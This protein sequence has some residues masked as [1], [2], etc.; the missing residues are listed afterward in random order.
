LVQCR[1]KGAANYGNKSEGVAEGPESKKF[2][3]TYELQNG[4]VKE[5]IMIGKDANA[6][7]KYFEFK[8][9]HKPISV[10]EQGVA[11]GQ[12]N[13]NGIDISMEI[14]KDDEYVD[15]EDYDNQVIYVTA[16]SKGKELGHVLFAFDGEYLMPQDLEVEERYRGQGIAQTMYDYVKSKGYKIRRSGQQT[17][18]GT[19]FW[20]KH[21]PGKNV[22]EQGVAE[23]LWDQHTSIPEL[24]Q[25]IKN[26]IMGYKGGVNLTDKGRAQLLLSINKGKRILAKKKQQQD[27]AEGRMVKGPGGVP[28]DRQGRPIVAKAKPLGMRK[29]LVIHDGSHGEGGKDIIEAPNAE[30]AW[31]LA[32]EYDLYIIDIKPYRGPAGPT[33]V[34]ESVLDEAV[35]MMIKGAAISG[36]DD[37]D[38]ADRIAAR[39]G[40]RVQGGSRGHHILII[41]PTTQ[42]RA[43]AAKKIRKM[44]PGIELYKSGGNRN[45]ID[46]GMKADELSQYCEELVAEKGWDQAYKHARFMAQGSTD[47]SWGSVLKYLKSMKDG[48]AEEESEAASQRKQYP[49][50]YQHRDSGT[51]FR[52]QNANGQR[53]DIT[54]DDEEWDDYYKQQFKDM[55]TPND[56]GFWN[57]D[58]TA[59]YVEGSAEQ[60]VAEV[61]LGDYRKKAQVS[62]AGAKIN[63][64]FDRDNP[65]KVARAD[66]TIA[67]RER[68]LARADARS[69]PYTA[70]PVDKEKQRQQLTDKYPNIDQLVSDA[71]KNRDPYYDRAEGNAYY[72]GREAEQNYV[73]LKQIQRIIQG[74]NEETRQATV[75]TPAGNFTANITKDKST[76]TV[77]GTMPVGGAT[78]SAKKDLTPGGAQSVT[79]DTDVAP[80][81]NLSATRKSADY[82]KGQLAGTK[83]VSAKYT[84]TT[85]ALGEPGQQ[86]TATRTA[87]VGFGGASGSRVGK[88]YVT[89]IDKTL[90][91]YMKEAKG[92]NSIRNPNDLQPLEGGGGMGGGGGY[93]GGPSPFKGWFGGAKPGSR[94]ASVAQNNP[95]TMTVRQGP[96][97]DYRPQTT[98]DKPKVN[99]KPGE[100]MD[101]AV[102]RTKTQQEFGKFLQGQSGQTFGA[103]G[104]RGGQGGP[105]AAQANTMSNAPVSVKNKP[106]AINSMARD[107]TN[108]PKSTNTTTTT[109]NNSPRQNDRVDPLDMPRDPYMP[110]DPLD[111][112]RPGYDGQLGSNPGPNTADKKSS[113]LGKTA[114]GLGYA[115]GAYGAADLG[116]R[117]LDYY[118]QT[119]DQSQDEV[120]IPDIKETKKREQPEVEYDD[121]YDAMVARVKRLAG[122]GP[123]KTVYDP[124]KRQYRNMPTAQQP[125][126]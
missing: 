85:G 73:R 81:L 113:W 92:I 47:P 66:Q 7:A 50:Y 1:K 42:D 39:T 125:K 89:Q 105:T 123:M 71:E 43:I 63:R 17:D 14:Q 72:A 117:A 27:M 40:G 121:D 77:S 9:R 110:R 16:S 100:T 79:V 10:V 103:G 37:Q 70:P 34:D 76:N 31:E 3:V 30:T 48:V 86:H 21:K 82:N 75:N 98:G 26:L 55:P 8:Y 93:T 120:I 59:A 74:L 4:D 111:M 33:L 49:N 68:G 109:T 18:A 112:I 102:Q 64:F 101:Q 65:E 116:S 12:E 20:D 35:G 84:D 96:N 11:E 83:S 53:M 54:P 107:L 58:N 45:A 29:W 22:W 67:K 104:G 119:K 87:G 80:N 124:K 19:G 60:G 69:R 32:N 126:K 88:N 44:F 90:A 106:S 13:F 2:K 118:D 97:P 23:G 78:L 51:V 114:K 25:A 52:T 108:P 36:P 99:V 95:N 46:E 38:I 56:G 91:D 24:E 41:Y 57:D 5:K 62:Q 115:A 6:V 61:S 15:D 122:L 94:E 28:L